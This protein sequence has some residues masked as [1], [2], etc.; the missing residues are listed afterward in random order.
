MPYHTIGVAKYEALGIQ[1]KLSA[2][3][4]PP[5]EHIKQVEGLFVSAGLPVI[6]YSGRAI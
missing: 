6:I 2:L 1:Y 3:Q 4:P 5:A